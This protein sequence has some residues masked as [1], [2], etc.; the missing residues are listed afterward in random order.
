[1]TALREWH[2]G[3]GREDLSKSTTS[4]RIRSDAN[5]RRGW[6]LCSGTCEEIGWWKL[7]EA[8]GTL[9]SLRKKLPL[10]GFPDVIVTFGCISSPLPPSLQL[11]SLKL[12][13]SG[14][15]S[16]LSEAS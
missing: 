10:Q 9:S 14:V 4:R 12:K 2:S 13:E 1:M 15:E 16:R 11:L 3:D 7:R 5:Y 6:S 8:G